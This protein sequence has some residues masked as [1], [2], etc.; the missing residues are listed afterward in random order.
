MSYPPL[1]RD[2]DLAAFPGAPFP[3][4]VI[5]AVEAS[6]RADAGNWHIAPEVRETVS[7]RPRSWWLLPL[8][9]LRVVTLTSVT[10]GTGTLVDPTNYYLDDTALV[11]RLNYRWDPLQ[12]YTV[13]MTHGYS[14]AED[15]LLVIA[16]R[17][18]RAVKDATLTQRSETVG[19]R[20][21]SESYNVNR[22]DDTAGSTGSGSPIDR[23]TIRTF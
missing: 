2:S 18:Q 9:T 21:R 20:T 12:T 1:T 5:R 4:A 10:D 6:V 3:T 22:I 7:V 23:Y 19:Q 13:D 15:L 8:P 14:A 17:C 16:A 11:T